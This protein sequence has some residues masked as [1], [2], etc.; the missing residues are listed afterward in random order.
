MREGVVISPMDS[1]GT[2]DENTSENSRGRR[3]FKSGHPDENWAE[4]SLNEDVEGDFRGR[5]EGGTDGQESV[6]DGE[7][8]KTTEEDN[9]KLVMG[10]STKLRIGEASD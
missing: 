7:D 3:R 1:Q 10:G 6:R 9:R 4:E 2:D 5:D 8:N